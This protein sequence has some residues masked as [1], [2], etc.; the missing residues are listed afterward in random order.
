MVAEPQISPGGKFVRAVLPWLI[1]GGALAVYVLTLNHWV[2]FNSLG[3]GNLG[4][5]ART[6]GWIWQPEL[7]G[8]VNWLVTYPFRWL[9]LKAIPLALNLFSALCAALTLALL[10]RSVALLPH[11]R[12]D[13]QR[14]KEQGEFSL[15]SIRSAWLP[16]VMAA[17]VCSLQLTFLE[18]ATTFTTGMTGAATPSPWGAGCEMLDLLLFAYVI[19]CVLEF[20]IHERESWLTRAAFVYGAAVTNNWAMIGFFPLLLTALIWIKGLDFFNARFLTR[21]FLWGLAALS[22]YLL[23]PLV[24]S[25]ADIAPTPFWPALKVNL[26]SQKLILGQL[27]GFFRQAHQDALL[28]AVTSLLPILVISI[29]WASYF[30][31]TSRLGVALT[32]AIFHLVHG[33][34]LVVCIWVALDPPFSPRFS[35]LGKEPGIPFLRLSY[36]SALSIGYFS[37]YF[38]LIFGGGADRPQRQPLYLRLINFVILSVVWLLLLIAPAALI[39]RN[40]PQIRVTNG[41]ILKQYADSMYQTLPLGAIVLSDDPRRLLLMQSAAAQSGKNKDLMFLD[42]ASLQFPEYH[43]Y[44]KKKYPQ[45]WQSVPKERK[46]LVDQAT[47]LQLISKFAKSNNVYYLH[48]SFGYYF[49]VFWAEPHG[50]VYKLNPYP[51]NILIAPLPTKD[52]IE[53]NEKFWT[54][55]QETT[56]TP[57]LRV[58]TPPGPANRAELSFR[59]MQQAHLKQEPNRAATVLAEFYSRALNYW[60]VEMQRS[61]QLPGAAAHFD[62]ALELNSDNIVAQLNLE[63]NKNLQAGRKSSIQLTR[64][65]E[66]QFGKYRNWDQIMGQN[67]PFDEPNACYE[68]G[69]I[70][71]P[72]GLYR[73]AAYQFDRAKTLAPDNV[74]ARLWLA[75]LYILSQMP[76]Q[77]LKLIEEIHAQPDL[78]R[79]TRTNQNEVLFVEASAHLAA[80][81]PQGAQA[82][83]D[84]VLK[85]YPA[86]E[87]LLATA[88]QVYMNYADYSNALPIIEK[89]LQLTPDNQSALVNKGFAS[90]QINA[91]EQA[92][93]PLTRVLT[94]QSNYYPAMLNR[95]IAYLRSDHLDAAKQDYEVLQKALPTAYQIYYGLGE[96]AY[97]KKETNA[98]IRSYTLYLTN[99][100]R[101]TEEA[102]FISGRLKELRPGSR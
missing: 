57:L 71:V 91:Y 37:G 79:I 28:L 89:Q 31:D 68:Q 21:M 62:R 5:V 80:H 2:S 42:T 76:D 77:S 38:L 81:D 33:V 66:D 102:R 12:T 14:Q 45:R 20:R 100:P 30:G 4:Q 41:P 61:G 98:A 32:T 52:L 92:I 27:I 17:L 69:R 85:K 35:P 15:L 24:Q 97:R 16:P 60:G 34:F 22:L 43:K 29:R 72:N 53:E 7:F 49:D 95:A 36:L 8:P 64:P 44:L 23:L 101:D 59:L 1:G 10:A 54:R 90:L 40:L 55:A 50:L 83:V 56:I 86:D 67:G 48:P 18:N 94:M 19:R 63:C 70:F 9:P 46:Q 82:A 93:P 58:I 11:D 25:T 47:L 84:T 13:E 78:L 99:S 96:I 26:A 87:D 88:T 51:T 75:Q 39:Y 65:V 6:S 3:R 73:Q 74:A